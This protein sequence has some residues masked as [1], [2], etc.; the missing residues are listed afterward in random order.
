MLLSHDWLSVTPPGSPSGFF[1]H[2]ILQARMLE[3]VAIP[4]PRESSRSRGQT[5]PS[6]QADSLP[7]EPP[8][9]RFQPPVLSK[10]LMQCVW[11]LAVFPFAQVLSTC[12]VCFPTCNIISILSISSFWTILEDSEY[13]LG[14]LGGLVLLGAMSQR[15]WIYLASLVSPRYTSL[16]L[17]QKQWSVTPAQCGF[18]WILSSCQNG[19]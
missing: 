13:I 14:R 5:W 2:G 7:S 18:D 1:I 15:L 8:G 3:H 19:S 6:L 17:A 11:V 4:F 16:H 12:H 10:R 9:K